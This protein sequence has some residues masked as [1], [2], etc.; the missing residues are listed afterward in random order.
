MLLS[1]LLCLPN[2]MAVDYKGDLTRDGAVD[3]ADAI[4]V[5]RHVVQSA[6]VAP[7]SIRFGDMD[8]S[9][10]LDVTD[11]V[12][13]LRVAVKLDPLEMLTPPDPVNE[14]PYLLRQLRPGD[15]WEYSE[16]N[17]DIQSYDG[18]REITNSSAVS[19]DTVLSETAVAP[20]GDP[21]L[22]M[23]ESYTEK[24]GDNGVTYIGRTYFGQDQQRNVW[25]YGIIELDHSKLKWVTDRRFLRWPGTFTLTYDQLP[26]TVFYESGGSQTYGR[27]RAVGEETVTVPAGTFKC[28]KLD[29]EETGRA[30]S[31]NHTIWFHPPTGSF[32]KGQ[33]VSKEWSLTD[34]S[35]VEEFRS[36]TE[37]TKVTLSNG[38]AP[39]SVP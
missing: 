36:T 31:H 28:I 39:Q 17:Q 3:V 16:T 26:M 30:S 22:I 15:R 25:I 32:V 19:I 4:G 38:P 29:Y 9:E 1:T 2:V 11:A 7:D 37:L 10:G 21:L 14:S 33:G 12:K 24:F 13:I 23:E 34:A 27:M 18:E 6:T 5:L 8:A 20:G 35:S